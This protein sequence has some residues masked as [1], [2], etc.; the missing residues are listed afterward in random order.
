MLDYISA[1]KVCNRELLPFG[2]PVFKEE[3][4][5]IL[6]LSYIVNKANN[7]LPLS[8]L[9]LLSVFKIMIHGPNCELSFE[10]EGRPAGDPLGKSNWSKGSAEVKR[11]SYVLLSCP[12]WRP[13]QSCQALPWK[14]SPWSLPRQVT[15][16]TVHIPHICHEPTS[17]A[18]VN[19]FWPV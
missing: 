11:W 12:L 13:R 4:W 5:P 1:L 16:V 7:W 3:N 6:N 18:R 14:R 15:W 8:F 2:Y 19:F 10:P 9:I 17:E